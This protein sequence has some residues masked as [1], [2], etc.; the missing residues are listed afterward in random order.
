MYINAFCAAVPEE[1]KQDYIKH[2]S[3]AGEIMKSC[4]CV[5]YKEAWG[6]AVP[7]GE[8]TSFLKA[9]KCGEG[10]VVVIGFAQWPDKETADAGAAPVPTSTIRPS[11]TE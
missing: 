8:T 5:S 6:D 3:I 1:N 7:D 2:A 10:E 4:G 9:V 11:S